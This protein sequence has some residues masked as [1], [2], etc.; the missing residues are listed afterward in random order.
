MATGTPVLASFDN[1]TEMESMIRKEKVGLFSDSDDFKGLADNILKLYT[2]GDLKV[3]FGINARAYVES[4]LNRRAC[5][6]KYIDT[7]METV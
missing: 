3:K 2:D 6:Q 1:G 4:N 5:T 7:I